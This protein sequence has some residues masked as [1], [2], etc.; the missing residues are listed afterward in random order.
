MT[1]SIDRISKD[2]RDVKNIKPLTKNDILDFFSTGISIPLLQLA[3]KYILL[4][5]H[6]LELFQQQKTVPPLKRILTFQRVSAKQDVVAVNG[7]EPSAKIPVKV[8]DVKAWK[9]SLHLSTVA[10]PVKHL[11]EFEEVGS[12]L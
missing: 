2:Y 12:K 4:H 3:R 1:N 7:H 10:I 6:L 11:S 5:R 8:V 9:E